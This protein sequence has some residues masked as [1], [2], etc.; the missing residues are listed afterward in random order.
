MPQNSITSIVQTPDGYLWLGTFGGLVRFDDVKFTPAGRTS[1][2]KVFNQTGAIGITGAAIN[3][4]KSCSNTKPPDAN[5][6]AFLSTTCSTETKGLHFASL[7]SH[8]DSPG[9]IGR[10]PAGHFAPPF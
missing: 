6:A 3:F 1:W 7:I 8:F 9:M 4:T 2:L 5:Q 10:S